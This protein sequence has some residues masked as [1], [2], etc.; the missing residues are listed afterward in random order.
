MTYRREE[1]LSTYELMRWL[2][3]NKITGGYHYPPESECIT[4]YPRYDYPGSRAYQQKRSPR[5]ENRK[6]SKPRAKGPARKSNDGK[7]ANGISK[8]KKSMQSSGPKTEKSTN[9][10]SKSAKVDSVCPL[11]SVSRL[12]TLRP[13]GQHRRFKTGKPPAAFEGELHLMR[14]QIRV[15]LPRRA[16]VEAL[17]PKGFFIVR[18]SRKVR[19]T[20]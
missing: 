5:Q 2:Q 18:Y 19:Q 8:S 17:T 9:R 14:L 1:H 11:Q 13:R 10:K 7:A 4:F 16:K 15:L 20:E 12:R 6:K 3:A